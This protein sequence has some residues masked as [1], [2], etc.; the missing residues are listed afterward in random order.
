[1]HGSATLS[2]D[3]SEGIVQV[4]ALRY[5]GW[6]HPGARARRRVVET[7]RSA[8][9]VLQP[10]EDPPAWHLRC[11]HCG[12]FAL[13]RMGRI[14]PAASGLICHRTAT[15]PLCMIHSIHIPAGADQ[16]SRLRRLATRSFALVADFSNKRTRFHLPWRVSVRPIHACILPG[17]KN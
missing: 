10:R 7:L 15:R 17:T 12:A 9:I 2:G 16:R 11:H 3:A 5:L 14:K 8:V 13:V 6:M 1:V 4:P